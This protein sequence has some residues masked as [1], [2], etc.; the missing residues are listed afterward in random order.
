VREGLAERLRESLRDADLHRELAQVVE[1]VE[2]DRVR[3]EHAR[4][5]DPH[6]LAVA[7]ACGSW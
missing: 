1:L 7:I 4:G 2:Q 5:V 6:G 3:H